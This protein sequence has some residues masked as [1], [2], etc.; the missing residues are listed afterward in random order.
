MR[1]VLLLVN[2]VGGKGKGKSI[3]KESALPILEAAGCVLDVRGK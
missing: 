2:P 3:V 1:R